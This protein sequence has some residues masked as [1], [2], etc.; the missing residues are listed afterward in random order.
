M[1]TSCHPIFI[2]YSLLIL[3]FDSIL[4]FELYTASLNNHTEDKTS[5]YCITEKKYHIPLYEES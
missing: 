5:Y 1:T 4:Q 2:H 3:I